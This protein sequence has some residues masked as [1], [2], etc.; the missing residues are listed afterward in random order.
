M[1]Q[2]CT[3]FGQARPWPAQAK[4]SG[5]QYQIC[6]IGDS[7]TCIRLGGHVPLQ[8]NLGPRETRHSGSVSKTDCWNDWGGDVRDSGCTSWQATDPQMSQASPF[9]SKRKVKVVWLRRRCTTASE[10]FETFPCASTSK[11]K[12]GSKDSQHHGVLWFSFSPPCHRFLPE[13]GWG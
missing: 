12:F 8:M 3:G 9:F 11:R 10:A 2:H 6:K 5:D 7:C 4:V 13:D 1:L